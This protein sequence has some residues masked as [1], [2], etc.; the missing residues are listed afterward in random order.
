MVHHSSFPSCCF[1]VRVDYVVAELHHI[2]RDYIFVDRAVLAA[3]R[4]NRVLED[5]ACPRVEWNHDVA[6]F[7]IHW[8]FISIE[9][10]K[11]DYF[12]AVV[13]GLIDLLFR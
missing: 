10:V 7:F 2:E 1:C 11:V 12:P 9:L 13:N 6:V 4:V 8:W 3:H 5:V